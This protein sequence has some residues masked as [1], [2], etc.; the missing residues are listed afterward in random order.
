M[1]KIK[2]DQLEGSTGNTITIP[3]GTTLDISSATFVQPTVPTNKGGTGLTS[4]GSA[5]Q[6]LKVNS[7]ASGLE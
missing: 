2:V 1:S 6:L 4:I 3:V 5:N 7:G